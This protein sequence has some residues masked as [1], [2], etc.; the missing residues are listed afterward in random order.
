MSTTSARTALVARDHIPSN[1]ADLSNHVC[2]FALTK[3]DGTPFNAS[4]ILE[5]DIIEICVWFGHTNPERVLWY[6]AIKSV[7]LFHTMDELQVMMCG[8]VKAMM[9][10]NEAIRVRTSHLLSLM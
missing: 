8:V 7:M 10:H 9:L 1:I 2:L 5:E 4:S 6:S 3:G